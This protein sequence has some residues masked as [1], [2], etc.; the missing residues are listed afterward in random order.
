MN[1][2]VHQIDVFIEKNNVCKYVQSCKKQHVN[3]EQLIVIGIA[4]I[5]Y[6]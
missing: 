6:V 5:I 1:H 4:T 2:N 3:K